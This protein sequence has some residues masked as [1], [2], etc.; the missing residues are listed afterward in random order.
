M[1]SK[2]KT[3]PQTD[4]DLD[5]SSAPLIE[6][7]TELRTR[8]IWS[9]VAFI[10]AMVLSYTIWNPI[11][12]VLTQPICH[13]L[14][15]RGQECGLILLKLQEGFFVAVRISLLGG[16]V[17]A[18]PIIGYQMWR[19][20]APGL[21]RNEKAAF[22][23]FLIASPVM[24]FIGGSFAFYVI[25]PMAYDFFLSFQQG[26]L[27]LPDDA[28]AAGAAAAPDASALAAIVFQ[29][30][31]D[32]YLSLTIKFILAFGLSFQLP[33]LLTLMGK[34][35]L[36]S[37][38]GLGSVRRYAVVAILALAAVATPPDVIS[39]VVLFVVIYGLYEVSIQLV[40]RI[41]RKREAELRAQGLWVD[42]DEDEGD[43]KEPAR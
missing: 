12:N 37:A 27:Q 25:L 40:A 23:P 42:D 19:F 35:G 41:E 39:Q 24:F 4:D 28:T 32:E 36:V 7:L 30:S 38:E 2:T 15:E 11:Y 14:E 43:D 9:M 26:P 16:F 6:H 5:D 29:G 18:F 3:K 1:A 20:V 34:A 10:V 22:F 33:V 17:L 31:V 8:I 13:A 21:Y